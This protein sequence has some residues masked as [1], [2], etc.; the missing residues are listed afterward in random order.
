MDYGY[1]LGYA[2]GRAMIW[3]RRMVEVIVD[4]AKRV[5]LLISDAI[6]TIREAIDVSD[7]AIETRDKF[8][9]VRCIGVPMECKTNYRVYRL[10]RSRC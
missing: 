6:D 10:P 2:I 7:Y 4:T 9:F 1:E 8:R 3:L 5:G